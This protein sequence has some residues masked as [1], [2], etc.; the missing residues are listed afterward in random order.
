VLTDPDAVI[1]SIVTLCTF[2][3]KAFGKAVKIEH[4][5]PFR[6]LRGG[7]MTVGSIDFVWYTSEEECVLVDFK[8]LPF[9]GREILDPVN[10]RYVGH[11][12][13]QQRAYR[14]ALVHAKKTVLATIIYLAMQG[15]VVELRV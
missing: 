14:E 9:A 4:E 6:E 10:S 15:R 12:A 3:T 1:A 11:Y 2:L 13:P 7:Q 5:L 8:N